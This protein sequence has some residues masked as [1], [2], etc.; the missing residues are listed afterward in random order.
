[1]MNIIT[2]QHGCTTAI[3]SRVGEFTAHGAFVP[4][5]FGRATV[6][7]LETVTEEVPAVI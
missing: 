2:Q 5:I 4:L 7:Q 3:D 6:G 1:M